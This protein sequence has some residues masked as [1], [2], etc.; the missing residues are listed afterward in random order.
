M[1]WYLQDNFKA[2][3]NKLSF[4]KKLVNFNSIIFTSSNLNDFS[5]SVKLVAKNKI[6]SG[7]KNIFINQSKNEFK[8]NIVIKKGNYV[9]Q[10]YFKGNEISIDCYFSSKNNKLINIVPRNRNII[11]SGESSLTTVINNKSIYFN[12]IKQIGKIFKFSGHIMFQCFCLKRAS[13]FE[14]NPRIG[15]A[16][17]V[18][19]YNSMDSIYYFI[20]ENIFPKKIKI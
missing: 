18:S 2:C 16:S 8:K 5:N 12:E 11:V 6:G 17:F 9:F 10:K 14:C 3:L 15:G 4:Y 1:L 19:Y 20:S 13:N 7:S